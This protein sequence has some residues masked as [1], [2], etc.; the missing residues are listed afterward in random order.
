[1]TVGIWELNYEDER[2]T[3]A[4]T[5]TTEDFTNSSLDGLS[6]AMA[7]LA[8]VEKIG[9]GGL[10]VI[11]AVFASVVWVRLGFKNQISN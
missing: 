11:P 4:V 7:W 1:M 3:R 2:K 10:Y 8:L 5:K 9:I 6:E